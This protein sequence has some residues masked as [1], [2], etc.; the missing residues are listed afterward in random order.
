MP[1]SSTYKKIDIEISQIFFN[2]NIINLF[3][4][5]SIILGLYIFHGLIIKY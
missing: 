2:F 4:K 3:K 1:N 5:C